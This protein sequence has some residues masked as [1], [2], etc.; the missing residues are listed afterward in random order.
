MLGKGEKNMYVVFN[1]QLVCNG[2]KSIEH[3]DISVELFYWSPDAVPLLTK[4]AHAA[5]KWVCK[6]ENENWLEHAVMTK[7]P[8]GYVDARWARNAYERKIIP[9][10]Y[11]SLNYSGWQ[12]QKPKNAFMGEHDA[13]FPVLH[14]DLKVRQLMISDYTNLTN[15]LDS[16]MFRTNGYGRIVGFKKFYKFYNLGPIEK[17]K[18]SA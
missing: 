7:T 5:A 11:S 18:G 10:I 2:F 8:G 9:I 13:W 3:P 12:C 17:F 4:Q 1:D 6:P 15:S 16:N 14:C